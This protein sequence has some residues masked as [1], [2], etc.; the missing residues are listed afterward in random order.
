MSNEIKR[1]IDYPMV[2][3]PGGEIELREDRIKSIWKAEIRPFLR[4]CGA[5]CRRRSHPSF[6]IDDVGFR[7]S[8]SI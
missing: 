3:T 5:S 8:Q 2:K 7:L 4:G 1:Y 6:S